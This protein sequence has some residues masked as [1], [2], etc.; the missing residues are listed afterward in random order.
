M[1]VVATTPRV[2][3]PRNWVEWALSEWGK[4]GVLWGHRFQSPQGERLP[5]SY[6]EPHF[7]LT[8][9]TR[10]NTPTLNPH[11]QNPHQSIVFPDLFAGGGGGHSGGGQLRHLNEVVEANG[12]WCKAQAS[13]SRRAR[14]T[15]REH[16]TD[17]RLMLNLLLRFSQAL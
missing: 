12:R 4:Q 9:E 3:E 15:I 10:L 17:V 13:G 8:D 7:S 5:A 1:P 11:I 2:L 14:V 16:Y 6:F